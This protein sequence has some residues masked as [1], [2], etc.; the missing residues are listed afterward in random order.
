MFDNAKDPLSPDPA[1]RRALRPED[2]RIGVRC[3][4]R[5]LQLIDSFVIHGD[6]RNRSDLV[7]SA[8]RAFLKSKA[9]AS[10]PPLPTPNDPHG[11]V[12]V[13]VR[14][15]RDEVEALEAYGQLASNGQPLSD[16]LAQL[17]RRGELELKVTETV[18]RSRSAVREAG[19]T[20]RRLE[21]LG[22]SGG[23]LERRG[24]VGR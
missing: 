5:E 3:N 18:A 24:V 2:E 21:E 1:A 11:L 10:V 16:L 8:L 22:R 23:D 17:V 6:F 4:R 12:E 14:L 7:R 9:S 13:V 19:E 15:R 20:R